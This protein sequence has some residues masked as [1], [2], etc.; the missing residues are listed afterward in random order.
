MLLLRN[1]LVFG[2]HALLSLPCYN[3]IL[4]A[5]SGDVGRTERWRDDDISQ[6]VLT[7]EDDLQVRPAVLL[8]LRPK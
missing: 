3:N 8:G 4:L 6:D 2:S 7:G 5:G 1:Q